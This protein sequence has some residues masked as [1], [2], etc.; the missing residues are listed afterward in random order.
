M[1]KEKS[2]QSKSG[3]SGSKEAVPQPLPAATDEEDDS[4]QWQVM[5]PKNKGCMTRKTSLS[6]SPISEMFVGQ[7]CSALNRANSLKSTTLQPFFTLQL[8]IQVISSWM[9]SFLV[10]SWLDG[11]LCVSYL[12][13]MASNQR[14]VLFLNLKLKSSKIVLQMWQSKQFQRVDS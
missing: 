7:M 4:E 9:P 6:K 5:G 11:P 10:L 1:Q 13:Y 12:I 3:Q 8:D 2:A 14:N